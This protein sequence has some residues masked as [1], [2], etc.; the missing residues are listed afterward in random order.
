MHFDK[1]NKIVKRVINNWSRNKLVPLIA[2]AFVIGS[3][4][5]VLVNT[6]KLSA[7]FN[8]QTMQNNDAGSFLNMFDK[9]VFNG[10]DKGDNGQSANDNAEEQKSLEEGNDELVQEQNK[11]KDDGLVIA[12]GNNNVNPGGTGAAVSSDG[13]GTAT[14]GG[15]AGADGA[16]GIGTGNGTA[17]EAAINVSTGSSAGN[18]ENGSQ[19]GNQPGGTGNQNTPDPLVHTD[20][21]NAAYGYDPG[22]STV[23]ENK[24]TEECFEHKYKYRLVV[25]QNSIPYICTGESVTT[26]LMDEN[27]TVTLVCMN[28][29]ANSAVNTAIRIEN[30][31]YIYKNDPAAYGGDYIID[32]NADTPEIESTVVSM[33]GEASAAIYLYDRTTGNPVLGTKQII[34]Y[35][36]VDYRVKLMD[37]EEPLLQNNG[38]AFVQT[39]KAST[40]RTISLADAQ[41]QMNKKIIER[42]ESLDKYKYIFKK[43]NS[44]NYLNFFKGWS[45]TPGG[46]AVGTN[47]T[48]RSAAQS[49]LHENI[50]SSP[51]T[52][53]Y[54]VTLYPVWNETIEDISD[55]K[56]AVDEDGAFVI[57]GYRGDALTV[58]TLN[59][60]EGITELD[61]NSLSSGYFPN[62]KLIHIPA[63]VTNIIFPETMSAYPALEAFGV[64]RENTCYMDVAGMLYNKPGTVLLRVPPVLKSPITWSK[65]AIGIDGYAFKG[66]TMSEL[67]LPNSIHKLEDYAFLDCKIG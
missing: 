21:E 6:D 59:I 16:N 2:C 40:G 54:E 58:E 33:P 14:V 41:K 52:Y 29:T 47:Y 38:N 31:R 35:I 37:F 18:T 11:K 67:V 28:A 13:S 20:P 30:I 51:V 4:G 48:I 27:V 49:E 5:I 62:L 15:S 9:N 55:F 32:W 44:N 8:P 56:V 63:E 26:Q 46:K 65:Y 12:S 57:D 10:D 36:A 53:Y 7:E 19:T 24:V 25:K 61:L 50:S 64:S 43:D 66:I 3:C 23:V 42:T 34:K 22:T 1:L 60:P 45:E 17:N 39:V